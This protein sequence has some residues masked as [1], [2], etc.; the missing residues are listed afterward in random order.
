MYQN[1]LTHVLKCSHTCSTMYYHV[2]QCITMYYNGLQYVLQC[3][4]LDQMLT[5]IIDYYP[6]CM[7]SPLL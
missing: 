7:Y 4:A 2:L 6:K 1:V 3:I 5:K